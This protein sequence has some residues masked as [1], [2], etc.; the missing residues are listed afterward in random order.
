MAPTEQI[1][2]GTRVA[3]AKRHTECSPHV[4]EGILAH[5]DEA[6][7]RR[8]ESDDS[9]GPMERRRRRGGGFS[10]FGRT[11]WNGAGEICMVKIW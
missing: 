6:V 11:A 3:Q 9:K 1:M 8:S 10:R 7:K 2:N 5:H 4:P